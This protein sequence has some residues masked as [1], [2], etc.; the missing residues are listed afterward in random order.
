MTA[1]LLERITLL[2]S[3]GPDPRRPWLE[4]PAERLQGGL[5]ALF[6][7]AGEQGMKLKDVLHGTWLGH[8]L[9]PA[10]IL[11]PAGSW[12][13]A[14]VLDIVGDEDGAQTAIGFGILASLPAAASGLV[15]WGYTEGRSRRVG[16]AHAAL[17]CAALGCYTLSWLA[18]KRGHRGLGVLLSTKGLVV[19]TVSAYLGGEIS[20]ALGHGVNRNAW[21]PDTGDTSEELD[22]FRPVAKLDDLREG[23]LSAA[24]IEVEGTKIPLVL[25]RRGRE[26]LALNGTCS[27]MSGPLAEGRLVDEWCVECPW[28]G[29]R[30]DFR[31]GEVTRGPATYP[32]PK[33]ETRVRDGQ[34]E[35]RV[36]RPSPDVLQQILT[37]T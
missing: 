26:V 3:D 19:M 8:A 36:A 12:L 27:H 13:T 5:M 30:F 14:A 7:G 33:F 29:S 11:G 10:L 28:H 34:V 24:E 32:Q 4:E 1:K 2:L 17:N 31:D 18:R 15:D 37:A 20:Y 21:S 6:D 23:R 35:A 9:H 25:M 16:L 22:D